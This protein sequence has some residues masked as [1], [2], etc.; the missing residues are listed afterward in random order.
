MTISGKE[1]I[2]QHL[3][4]E[5]IDAE[6]VSHRPNS[7]RTEPFTQGTHPLLP[8]PPI[9]TLLLTRAILI[10]PCPRRQLRVTQ[11]MR[12]GALRTNG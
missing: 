3:I 2:I 10:R 7:P 12:Q 1:K 6:N 11:F 8:T 9:Q 4:E 5:P